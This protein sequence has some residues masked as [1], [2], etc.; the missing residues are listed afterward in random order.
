[1]Q[2]YI[3]EKYRITKVACEIFVSCCGTCNRKRIVPKRGVVIKPILSD[4]F[5]VRGQVDLI[6]FQSCHDGEFNWLLNYQDHATKFLHLRPLR[7]KHAANVAE[8]LSKIFFT[9]GAPTIL[10]SDNG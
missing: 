2:Y 5:N 9:W 8:E 3:K 1:M 4:G 7:S 6:D 10:Q